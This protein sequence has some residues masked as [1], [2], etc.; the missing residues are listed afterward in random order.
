MAM[1]TSIWL[2]PA[3]PIAES[4]EARADGGCFGMF[5]ERG[6]ESAGGSIFCYFCKNVP[7]ASINF[8]QVSSSF[9][10]I[11]FIFLVEKRLVETTNCV[12]KQS[13]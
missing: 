4:A 13:F 11:T 1:E 6:V 12:A 5:W 10:T 7:S 2:G 9:P 8:D 3:E